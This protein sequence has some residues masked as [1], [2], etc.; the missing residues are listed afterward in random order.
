MKS[1]IM[2]W[3]NLWRN[4]RRTFITVAAIIMAVW[5]STLYTSM[6]EGTYNRMIDNVVKFYNGYAQIHDT[7]YWDSRSINDAFVCTDSLIEV[8]ENV[9]NVSG[10][11]K[12]IESFTLIS[13]GEMT[14]GCALIGI[15]PLKE[16]ELTEM[17]KWVKKGKYLKE[18]DKG[19]LLTKNIAKQIKADVGDTVILMSQGYHGASAADLF[20]VRGILTYPSP[21]M[22]NMGG[23]ISL[24]SAQSFFTAND[25]VTSA[26]LQIEST[27][28]LRN[29]VHKVQHVLGDDLSIMTWDKMQPELVQMIQSDRA[30]AIIFKGILYIVVGFGI[31]G[32]VI[33][34]IQERKRENAIMVAI[35]MRKKRLERILFFETILMG[36]VGLVAG[37]LLSLPLVAL[38]VENP[39]PLPEDYSEAMEMFGIEPAMFFSMDLVVFLRQVL[40]VF[41]ITL[42]VSL[43]PVL[44]VLNMKVISAMRH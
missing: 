6:Q 42:L 39:I 33:M 34:M 27:K 30:G 10:V 22:N 4:R 41:F 3:R 24:G 15:D 26:V 19:I 9:D 8:I 17:S 32:T 31:F 28:K 7:A 29:T 35:G 13:T 14:K 18:N 38:L 20:P 21:A 5:L 23:F 2:A 44:K 36:I 11:V 37:F 16:D 25:V 12:R 40:I 1:F 43:Y